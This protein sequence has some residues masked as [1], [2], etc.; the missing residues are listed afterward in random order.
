ESGGSRRGDRRLSGGDEISRSLRVGDAA[1]S[2]RFRR[3]HR[4]SRNKE[5]EGS[6]QKGRKNMTTQVL[7]TTQRPVID[8]GSLA[9]EGVWSRPRKQVL[10]LCALA[11]ALD[12]LDNQI[13]G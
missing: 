4:A 11:I 1:T 3:P 13:L 5:A 9:E 12:G 2:E 6:A 10:L 8:I 7:D